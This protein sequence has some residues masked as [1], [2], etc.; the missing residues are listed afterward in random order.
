MSSNVTVSFPGDGFVNVSSVNAFPP[1]WGPAASMANSGFYLCLFIIYFI[2][3]GLLLSL[4]RNRIKHQHVSSEKKVGEGIMKR[5]HIIMF[6][7]AGSMVAIQCINLLIRIVNDILFI[8]A[9]IIVERGER[10]SYSHYMAIWV[11]AGF[12][13]FFMFLNFIM[14]FVILFFV[15]MVL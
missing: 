6:L 13:S 5:N 8:R 1:I 2:C 15:Q 3:F 7:L 14:L 12:S 11:T 4:I 9:R 10:V